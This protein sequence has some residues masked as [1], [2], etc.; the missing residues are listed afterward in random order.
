M[1]SPVGL[2]QGLTYTVVSQVPLRD[3]QL[4]DRASTNYLPN[5]SNYYLQIPLKSRQNCK[6][7]L[8]I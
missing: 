6:N 8:K 2:Q 7:T 3:R 1:R 4:L 5:I